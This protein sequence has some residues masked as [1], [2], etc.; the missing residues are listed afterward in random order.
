[1]PT[2]RRGLLDHRQPDAGLLSQTDQPPRPPDH[3]RPGCPACLADVH[4]CYGHLRSKFLR[5]CACYWFMGHRHSHVVVE[6]VLHPRQPGDGAQSAGNGGP[7]ATARGPPDLAVDD[8]EPAGVRLGD[9]LEPVPGGGA[10]P[11]GR[12][13][14]PAAVHSG[15]SSGSVTARQTFAGDAGSRA[16]SG[17]RSVSQE[18]LLLDPGRLGWPLWAEA[19]GRRLRQGDLLGRHGVLPRAWVRSARLVTPSL[20]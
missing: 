13:P 8:A 5:V 17:C 1:M 2:A 14:C 7:S 6:P 3:L 16:R 19:F 18:Q 12:A 9:E 11:T 10:K 20:V 15:T 4:A